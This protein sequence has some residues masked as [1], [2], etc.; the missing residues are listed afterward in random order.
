[1]ALERWSRRG[2]RVGER[3]SSEARRLG[4]AKDCP[5]WRK[6]V[7]GGKGESAVGWEFAGLGIRSGD[8]EVFD[9]SGLP[10][11]GYLV[12]CMRIQELGDSV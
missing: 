1:M 12:H 7:C 4:D 10:E 6:N 2:V 8:G 9:V 11:R 3:E 5:R